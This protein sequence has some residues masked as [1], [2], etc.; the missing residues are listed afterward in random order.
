MKD[1]LSFNADVLNWYCTNVELKV[2]YEQEF[3][4]D[5]QG[6]MAD[7]E[8]CH[9]L[10]I[11]KDIHASLFCEFM[12]KRARGKT[13]VKTRACADAFEQFIQ[14]RYNAWKREQDY[15]ESNSYLYD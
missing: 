14:E 6:L 15:K 4:Q 11:M 8:F 5:R 13:Y 12:R 3:V 7:N 2:F 10:K 1:N 9:H